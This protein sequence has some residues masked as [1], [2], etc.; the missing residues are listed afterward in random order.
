MLGKSS[1]AEFYEFDA[2]IDESLAV[3]VG[4][5]EIGL[6]AL[7]G[8]DADM[9]ITVV[10]AQGFDYEACHIVAHKSLRRYGGIDVASVGLTVSVDDASRRIICVV[11]L[12]PR[13]YGGVEGT[14]IILAVAAERE[15][16]GIAE[17]GQ[18][19]FRT[20]RIL[21]AFGLGGYFVEFGS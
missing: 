1:V 14:K 9:E 16:F 20:E 21:E 7:V 18:P 4:E 12:E 17:K 19:V 10:I 8:C 11:V 3:A 6:H 13:I 15:P 5:I 2:C